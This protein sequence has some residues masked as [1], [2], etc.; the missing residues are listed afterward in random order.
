MDLAKRNFQLH[1][2]KAERIPPAK[3]LCL[4]R[5]EIRAWIRRA[6]GHGHGPLTSSGL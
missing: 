5:K 2:S 4:A 1:I 3:A 6:T